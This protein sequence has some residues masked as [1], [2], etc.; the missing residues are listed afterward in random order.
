GEYTWLDAGTLE[1]VLRYI[2][3]PH[4]ETFLCRFEGNAVSVDVKRSFN[5]NAP[6]AVVTLKGAVQ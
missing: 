2:E 6:D 3:S 5:S 4:T 1:L